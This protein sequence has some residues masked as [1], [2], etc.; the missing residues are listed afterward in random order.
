[1]GIR[2]LPTG[3]ARDL[4]N[5]RLQ[6]AIRAQESRHHLPRFLA[7]LSRAFGRDV[8]PQALLD[9]SETDRLWKD[10]DARAASVQKSHD[11]VAYRVPFSE[12]PLPPE[13]LALLAHLRT[14]PRVDLLLFHP[15]SQYCGAVVVASDVL[16]PAAP[17]LVEVDGETLAAMSR[18]GRNGLLIEASHDPPDRDITNILVWGP[19]WREA[20]IE[21]LSPLDAYRAGE[22]VVFST[23]RTVGFD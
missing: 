16:L 18:D 5:P 3:A 13:I 14:L 17:A 9:L 20:T 10:L 23:T 21:H 8:Q 7:Q 12:T 15:L 2:R 1:M 22:R 4:T 19:G 6:A 11:G